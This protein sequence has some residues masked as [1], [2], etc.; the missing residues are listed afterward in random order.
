M[1]CSPEKC[2]N[3]SDTR[4]QFLH[5]EL[6]LGNAEQIRSPH[7]EQIQGTRSTAA[8]GGVVDG[9]KSKNVS[10]KVYNAARKVSKALSAQDF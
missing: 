7:A 5:M 4:Q 3:N 8:I 2:R 10:P 1:T 6:P 9:S